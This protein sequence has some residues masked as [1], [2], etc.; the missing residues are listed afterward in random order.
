MVQ[1]KLDYCSVLWSPSD[2]ASIAR[3][4]S[5]ARHFTSQV[6]GMG[7]LDYWDRLTSLQMASQERRRE[8][9]S[10]IFVW[11]IAEQLVKGYSVSFSTNPRR[12][13]LAN[14]PV[15]PQH[16]APAVRKAR[17]GSLRVK[18]AK[19]FNIIPKELRDMTGTVEQFKAGLDQWLSSIPDQPTVAGRQRAAKT[20]SLLDQVHYAQT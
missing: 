15:P 7:E 1:P 11:K 2:Q 3:L 19:L 4:E 10:I 8:R 5:V 9:Y 16:V 6:A 13:R 18:G 20:N 14:V 12:G 17:D